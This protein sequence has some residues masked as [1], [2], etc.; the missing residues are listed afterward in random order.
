VS[1]RL[2]VP[3][4]GVD[5]SGTSGK[6]GDRKV[7][8]SPPDRCMR[9]ILPS[10]RA[11]HDALHQ[12][13]C[14]V[15]EHRLKD[16]AMT[17][18]RR[19]GQLLVCIGLCFTASGCP[20]FSDPTPFPSPSQGPGHSSGSPTD[21]ACAPP[22]GAPAWPGTCWRRYGSPSSPFYQQLPPNPQIAASSQTTISYLLGGMPGQDQNQGGKITIAADSEG[23]TGEPTYYSTPTDPQFAIHCVGVPEYNEP[24][25]QCPIEGHQVRIPAGAQR[26]GGPWAC[27][28]PTQDTVAN[29]EGSCLSDRHLTIEDQG[30]DHPDAHWEYDLWR[31]ESIGIGAQKSVI[32]QTGLPPNGGTVNIAR[33]GRVDTAST[34]LADPATSPDPP[35]GDGTSAGWGD[36][37][38]RLT[39]EDLQGSQP[40][41]HALFIDVQCVGTSGAGKSFVWPARKSGQL[42]SQVKV[43]PPTPPGNDSLAPPDGSLL[44]LNMTDD[45]INQVTSIGWQRKILEAMKNYGAYIGDTG[46][47]TWFGFETESSF[48]YLITGGYGAKQDPWW[49]VATA[50]QWEPYT[51]TTTDG[52]IKPGVAQLLGHLGDNSWKSLVWANLQVVDPC[53]PAGTCQPGP[54]SQPGRPS[55][56]PECAELLTGLANSRQALEGQLFHASEAQR[57]ALEKEIASINNELANPPKPP[58]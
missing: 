10:E 32:P 22:F 45:Q 53:V 35:K 31:V 58:C 19:F 52:T 37:A 54:P 50:N 43:K 57:A 18:F 46:V 26:E 38:G 47:G 1:N 41:Q 24:P 4:R 30:V 16:E 39:A 21:G 20:L 12:S 42:C 14:Q 5:P 49:T 33:G 28:D 29:E 23:Y 11:C 44:Y 55:E 17:A 56:S 51:T 2:H 6:S 40:I 48:E 13:P 25:G 9:R 7:A 15:A 34:G 27:G 36:L 3:D 8:R